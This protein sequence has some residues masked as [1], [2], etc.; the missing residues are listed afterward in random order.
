MPLQEYF[1]LLGLGGVKRRLYGNISRC[2]D[3]AAKIFYMAHM[4]TPRVARGGR[5]MASPLQ[6]V[7]AISFR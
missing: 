7:P 6:D 5:C 4:A 3:W 2:S 1:A